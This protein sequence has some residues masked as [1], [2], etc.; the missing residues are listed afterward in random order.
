MSSFQRYII[1]HV[2]GG[3]GGG[4]GGGIRAQKAFHGGRKI[5]LIDKLN[6]KSDIAVYHRFLISDLIG[7]R[8]VASEISL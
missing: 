7:A 4:G 5:F 8:I 2:F 1:K 3:G 6:I